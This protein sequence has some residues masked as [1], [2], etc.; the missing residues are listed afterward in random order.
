MRLRSPIWLA[1]IGSLLLAAPTAGGD[2]SDGIYIELRGSAAD[3]NLDLHLLHPRGAWDSAPWDCHWKNREPNW[4]DSG[5]AADDPSLLIPAARVW[6]AKS[7]TLSVLDRTFQGAQEGLLAGLGMA[8]RLF[9][10]IMGSLHTARPESCTLT[11]DEAY[12]F[13]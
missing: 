7:G 8:A 6:R 1:V 12:A 5:S 13:L 11:V 10:P 9:P 2:T 4:G 3:G